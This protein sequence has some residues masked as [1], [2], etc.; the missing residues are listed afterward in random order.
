[1]NKLLNIDELKASA[2]PSLLEQAFGEN[3]ISAFLHGNCLMEGFDALHLPWTVSFILK[4]NSPAEIEKLHPLV[5]RAR[6]E[7]IR[8]GY[9]FSPKEI[10]SALDTF[11]LEFLHIANRNVSLCG[12]TPLSGFE[13]HREK[14][15]LQCEHE[16]RGIL[17]HLREGFANTHPGKDMDAFASESIREALPVLYGVFY[18]QTGHYPESHQQVFERFPGLTEGNPIAAI[19]GIVDQV[20]SMEEK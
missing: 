12:I 3:L 11:P 18:L 2:W 20:D 15:R 9:F 10:V 6:K 8:F 19:N 14:L 4:D 16:L 7:N 13:P 17:V 1:M 5:K